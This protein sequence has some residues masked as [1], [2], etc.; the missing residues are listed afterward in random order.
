MENEILSIV[1]SLKKSFIEISNKISNTNPIHQSKIVS[2]NSSNDDVK[3]LDIFANDIIIHNLKQNSFISI[4]SSEENEKIIEN[5]SKGKYFVS[6]D[7]LDGSSNIDSNITTGTIFGI[8]LKD[9]I[10]NKTLGDS[11]VAAGYCLY[12][13]TTEL[14]FTYNNNNSILHYFLDETKT[15]IKTDDIIT[16]KN[17][18]YYSIN[19][20]NKY[21]WNDT[22]FNELIE[23]FIQKNYS[24]RYVG[25]LVADAHRTLIKG[26]FFSYPIDNKQKGKLRLLYECIPFCYIFSKAKCYAYVNSF[27]EKWENISFPKNIHQTC[28]LTLCSEYENSIILYR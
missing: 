8:Y 14:I 17:G 23:F 20:A 27:Q 10:E 4:I 9:N 7:P 24:Q 13:G 26:G 15:F 11:I 18:K 19:Q 6:F 2:T 3:K 21:K 12:G 1:S 28:G 5:N 25:S 16:P 22:K